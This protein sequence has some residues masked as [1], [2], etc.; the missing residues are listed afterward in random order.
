MLA[1]T[2]HMEKAEVRK[3]LIRGD[4]AQR[5]KSGHKTLSCKAYELFTSA[6]TDARKSEMQQPVLPNTTI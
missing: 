4:R 3:G 5:T 1:T 6:C 2:Q